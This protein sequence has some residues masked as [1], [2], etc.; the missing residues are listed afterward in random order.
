MEL[1]KITIQEE[2]DF[3]TPEELTSLVDS[4]PTHVREVNY[5]TKYSIVWYAK[6]SLYFTGSSYSWGIL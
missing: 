5:L 4:I 1:L 2:W 3:I 6:Y